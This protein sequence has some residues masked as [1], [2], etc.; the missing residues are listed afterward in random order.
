MS[1]TVV[2]DRESYAPGDTLRGRVQLDPLP[3]DASQKVELSVVWE[4][5]GK[6]DTDVGVVFYRVLSDGDPVAGVGEHTFDVLLPPLPLSYAGNL[7]KIG[8]RVRIRRLTTLGDDGVF[9]EP[10][11]LE[12]PELS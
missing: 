1:A 4:T 9:D 7:I 5:E 11:R 8:W 12:W 3:G 6:G 2:L 10:F